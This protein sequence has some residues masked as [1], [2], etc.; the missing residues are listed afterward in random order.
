MK[1]RVMYVAA[2]A[3]MASG[4]VFAQSSTQDTQSGR[5]ATV[6]P[7]TSGNTAPCAA[8]NDSAELNGNVNR[9]RPG[10]MGAPVTANPEWKGKRSTQQT[11]MNDNEKP[12]D[13]DSV[14]LRVDAG[15][16]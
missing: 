14:S 15:R 10:A 9:E 5:S 16:R 3:L 12:N 4:M 2:V 6:T 11:D 8:S 1:N 7:Q 13:E